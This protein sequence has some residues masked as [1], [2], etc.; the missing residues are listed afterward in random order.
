MKVRTTKIYI[1]CSIKRAIFAAFCKILNGVKKSKDKNICLDPLRGLNPGAGF[2]NSKPQNSEKIVTESCNGGCLKLPGT[3]TANGQNVD[4]L[5]HSL[6]F[7]A[8]ILY[9]LL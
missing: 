9:L 1:F 7:N 4:V 8:D 2:D 6:S 5:V 3:E